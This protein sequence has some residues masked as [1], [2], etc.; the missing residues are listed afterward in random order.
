MAG[1]TKID[2]HFDV[3]HGGFGLLLAE[4][5]SGA[6]LTDQ[7]KKIKNT[8][9]EFTFPVV[10]V[11]FSASGRLREKDQNHL[12]VSTRLE[13]LEL[14]IIVTPNNGGTQVKTIGLFPWETITSKP[15]EDLESVTPSFSSVLGPVTLGLGV[16]ISAFF[17]PQPKVLLKAFMGGRNEFGWYMKSQ[18]ERS[19]EGVH[20]TAA[21]LQVDREV[22]TLKL[23]GALATDWV[24]GD[25]DNQTK[26]INKTFKVN[27]PPVPQNPLLMDIT[28]PTNL[29]IVLRKEAVSS[30]LGRRVVNKLI[31]A[32][33]LVTYETH[34][35]VLITRASF[36]KLLGEKP[37][38]Q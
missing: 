35:A 19:C 33:K 32:N 27:H 25:V 9:N 34:N 36:L 37:V 2:I 15:A 16:A 28:D 30:I 4:Q 5:F 14:R 1:R 17:R 20:H 10:N 8:L 24:G 31:A 7:F 3:L 6:R 29:P 13:E 38:S 11:V 26:L 18:A 23:E 12:V 21:V 22:N